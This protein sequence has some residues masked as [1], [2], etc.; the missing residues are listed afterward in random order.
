MCFQKTG[1]KGKEERREEEV[2]VRA[3]EKIEVEVREVKGNKI[4]SEYRSQFV[5]RRIVI[6]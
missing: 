1:R 6:L 3:K 2:E 5:E 4:D